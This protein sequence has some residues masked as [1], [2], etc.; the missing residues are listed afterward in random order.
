M[1]D[2]TG[3]ALPSKLAKAARL[4]ELE[5]FKERRVYDVVSRTAMKP[6]AKLIGVRWVETNKGSLVAPKVRSRLVCQ[7][8]ARGSTLEEMFAPT[9][10]LVATRWLLSECASRGLGGP[11]DYRLMLLDFKRAFLY[12]DIQRTLYIELPEDDSRRNGGAN[13]GLLRKA[14]YGTQDAP[15]VWQQLVRQMLTGL[16][17]TPSTTV[18]CLYFNAKTRV[19]IVAHTYAGRR[20]VL[21]QAGFGQNKLPHGRPPGHSLCQQRVVAIYEFTYGWRR[22]EAEAAGALFGAVPAVGD[23][24]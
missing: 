8:F 4:E 24:V 20:G 15:S 2:I 23:T 11:G 5:V 16:G 17:F 7:E 12:G 19:S 10:P 22:T 18:A 6:G 1:D 14:M 3:E 9:P 21:V 13:V